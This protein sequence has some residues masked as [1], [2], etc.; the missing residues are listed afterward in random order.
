MVLSGDLAS[1]P[2]PFLEEKK[3]RL[4][5]GHATPEKIPKYRKWDTPLGMIASTRLP[6]SSSEPVTGKDA[7][8]IP[9]PT[10]CVLWDYGEKVQHRHKERRLLSFYTLL[11]LSAIFEKC[12]VFSKR[13]HWPRIYG[14]TCHCKEWT[15]N[16]LT[17]NDLLQEW[18]E[19]CWL[20]AKKS[21]ECCQVFTTMS[22]G[23]IKSRAFSF[24]VSIRY[25]L[26]GP[27]FH[28]TESFPVI[29][30]IGR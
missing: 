1:I 6:F 18:G 17:S 11:K 9:S 10:S 7:M 23:H 13:C 19:I 2:E 5:W 30:R 16:S 14:P 3:R 4:D 24:S 28:V 27:R 22:Y 8:M 15:V 25:R 21:S 26:M 12:G 20:D 29:S